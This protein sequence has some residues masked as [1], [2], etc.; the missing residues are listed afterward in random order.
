V[1][2]EADLIKQYVSNQLSEETGVLRQIS[3]SEKGQPLLKRFIYYRLEKQIK[4]FLAQSAEPRWIVIPGLRGVGKTTVLAQLFQ[5]F[6]GDFPNRI[7][8][9]SLDDVVNRINSNLYE[10]IDAYQELLGERLSAM[11]EKVLLL[12]DE[13]QYDKKWAFAL[14]T[15]YDRTKNVF[16]IATGSSAVALNVNTDIARR[17]LFEKMY[18][19]KFTEYAMISTFRAEGQNT[20][21]PPK[22]GYQIKDALFSS[23][24]SRAAYDRL[25]FLQT[26]VRAYWQEID[27][28]MI[29]KYLKYYSLPCTLLYK[30]EAQIY[31][32][33]NMVVDRIVERDVPLLKSFTAEKSAQIQRVLFMLAG[34][35]EMSLPT[36]VRGVENIDPRTLR[37]VL[38]VLEK[39]ELL[40]RVYPYGSIGKKV[41]KP[42]KYLFAAPSIR[43]A[44]LNI[45]DSKAIDLKYKG[46]L[47][48]DAVG[49]C[50]QREYGGQPLFALSYDSAKG[51]ADFILEIGGKRVVIEVGWGKRDA[52][53]VIGTMRRKKGAFGLLITNAL[54]NYDQ[55][56]N[57]VTVPLEYF[58]LI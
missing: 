57:I 4:D 44:L 26:A 11:K 18:P 48:E 5:R 29:G 14:K 31:S 7:I 27:P 8:Y 49:A 23:D 16:I 50:L 13:V 17:A 33:L 36:M 55:S 28:L 21:F 20:R 51:G 52:D 56:N 19:L 43:A 46:K 38:A 9:I 24:N 35:D 30:E 58:F 10:V 40:I 39:S 32:I 54:L 22:L 41:R 2:A 47:L 15:L 42:S 25:L 34:F 1:F 45:I 53:Q 6:K 12:V 37:G 3:S